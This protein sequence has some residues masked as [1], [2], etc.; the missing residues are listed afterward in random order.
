MRIA[1]VMLGKGFGGAERSFVDLCRALAAR[2]HSVLAIGERRGLALPALATTP[3]I[4]CLAITCHGAWDRLAGYRLQRALSTFDPAV[5]QAHLAR[6]ALLAGRAAHALGLPALAK[7]HNFVDPADYRYLDVLVPTTLAQEHHLLAH[8]VSPARLCRIPNFSLLPVAAAARRRATAVPRIK[9]LGRMVHKKGFDLLLEAA[10]LLRA[11]GRAFEL[12]IAGDGPE[13]ATLRH[14]AAL[15]DLAA[16][17]TL[18]PWV[19]DVATFLADADLFVL[20]SRDEPFGIVVLEAMACGVPIVA[21]ASAGPREILD[22]TTALLVEDFSAA[23]LARALAQAID[24]A[25]AA[26]SR[27]AAALTRYAGCYTAEVVVEAYLAL[28]ARLAHTRA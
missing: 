19:T 20:P 5:M 2:G 24:D 27:A 28:Y 8:G 13:L 15:S 12:V 18:A 4:E 1:Q 22:A 25:G 17:V 6:A 14:R 11:E 23:A 26:E 21:T 3:G 7:T 16:S 10:A 9:T